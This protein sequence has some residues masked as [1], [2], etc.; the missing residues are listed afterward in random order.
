MEAGQSWNFQHLVQHLNYVLL[1]TAVLLG[2][3]TMVFVYPNEFISIFFFFR[4]AVIWISSPEL[5]CLQQLCH[6]YMCSYVGRK[7][8]IKILVSSVTSEL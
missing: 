4:I 7:F 2:L 6:A 5:S 8:I 3:M 1:H